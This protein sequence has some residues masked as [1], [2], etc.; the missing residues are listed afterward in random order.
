MEKHR[1]FETKGR[2]V[3]P[4]SFYQLEEN[5]PTQS[6]PSSCPPLDAGTDSVFSTPVHPTKRRRTASSCLTPTSHPS[7]E[8]SPLRTPDL[9]LTPSPRS[10]VSS[11][12]LDLEFQ[13]IFDVRH[14]NQCPF[15][16][17]IFASKRYL[18]QHRC[19]FSTYNK[20]CDNTSPKVLTRPKNWRETKAIITQLCKEDIIK[21]CILQDWSLP[22]FYPFV[23]PHQDPIW[24]NWK[25]SFT[26]RDDCSKLQCPIASKHVG[27]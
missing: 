27:F 8:S 25:C 19:L 26:R 13:S 5:S 21:L 4:V 17:Y 23:F 11:I 16:L 14:P 10:S 18:K 6:R 2:T 3:S 15:C 24:K 12:P 20:L 7:W 1:Y 9:L 22:D